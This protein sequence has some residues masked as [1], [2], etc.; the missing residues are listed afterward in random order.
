MQ[1]FGFT[2]VSE[3][4][5]SSFENVWETWEVWCHSESLE[6]CLGWGRGWGV[7]SRNSIAR[8]SENCEN[9]RIELNE[10]QKSASTLYSF[11]CFLMINWTDFERV[12][13]AM[14]FTTVFTSQTCNKIPAW[15]EIPCKL[16][17]TQYTINRIS[18]GIN[19]RN[20][21]HTTSS[22]FVWHGSQQNNT[23]LCTLEKGTCNH[24]HTL[25]RL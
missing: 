18:I 22:Q 14:L 25:G 3:T 20:R 7:C 5:I 8:E 19:R 13:S 11:D 4:S 23:P 17:L 10:N 6:A 16:G 9:E 21:F 1:H 12:L 15:V 24:I 2:D